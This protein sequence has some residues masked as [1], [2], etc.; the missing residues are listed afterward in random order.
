MSSPTDPAP[1]SPVEAALAKL[2]AEADEWYEEHR[3]ID[4]VAKTNTINAGLAVSRM[5]RDGLPITPKR[6]VSDG[7]SQVRGLSGSRMRNIL[8]EHGET[9]K[10]TS[11]GGRTSRATLPK[12]EGLVKRWNAVDVSDVD[13]VSLAFQLE[14]FFVDKA[15]K[16]YF[17][18]KRLKVDINPSKPV[19]VT[20]GEILLAASQRADRPTGAVLQHLVGAKLELRFPSTDIGRDKATTA[21]QQ[22]DRE[23]DF[24]VGTT[25]FHVTVSPMEKLMDRCK[26]NIISGVRPTLI[27]PEAR[28]SA[29]RQLAEVAGIS[30]QVSVTEAETFIGTNIEEIAEY[31]TDSIKEGLARLIRRYNERI[32]EV[33][34]DASLRIEE[35]GWLVTLA[36]QQGF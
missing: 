14:E 18:K 30:D 33:E 34:P 26:D 3:K 21:D 2:L 32:T 24:Q 28:V 23:G 17:D 25:A 22:T 29:A 36:E 27:V 9:R 12:A 4:K 13:F 1:Q 15:R 8:A 20:V 31:D 16:D 19:A 6:L 5:V 35:P 7:G 10:Y 11:E